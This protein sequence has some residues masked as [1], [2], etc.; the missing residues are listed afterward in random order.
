M[1]KIQ[2]SFN[3]QKFDEQYLKYLEQ[4]FSKYDK[5]KS[6][7]LEKE[8]FI[9]WLVEGGTKR[10]IAKHIFY[11]VDSNH[12]GHLSFEDFKNYAVLQQNLII[13]GQTKEYAKM[14]FDAVDVDKKGKL[15]KK[16]FKKFMKIMST[17]VK[18]YK[19]S[20]VFKSYDTDNNGTIEFDEISR[21]IDFK[22]HLLLVSEECMESQ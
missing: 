12:D 17:P 5:D 10:K 20:H 4:E 15:N 14:V 11:V 22:N 18:R 2:I 6:G 7:R 8:E 13:K 3:V 1:E 21:M 19:L 16:Q 9:V